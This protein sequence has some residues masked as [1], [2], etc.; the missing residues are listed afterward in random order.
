MEGIAPP[1][2]VRA[3]YTPLTILRGNADKCL[4]FLRETAIKMKKKS[5]LLVVAVTGALLFTALPAQAA[6]LPGTLLDAPANGAGP[7]QRGR[8]ALQTKGLQLAGGLQTSGPLNGS[9]PAP[10][11]VRLTEEDWR[12]VFPRKDPAK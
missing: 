2:D 7:R 10:I 1:G 12:K 3:F 11:A 4:T 6:E 9:G 5:S 8:S